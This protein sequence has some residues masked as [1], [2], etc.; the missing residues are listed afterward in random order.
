MWHSVE[1]RTPFS[2]DI[3]LMQ[4]AF[5]FNGNRKIKN[6]VSKYFLRKAVKDVL[7]DQIYNRYD[8]VGFE[9]P[10][11]SWV[12]QLKPKIIE[13]ITEAKFE[14]VDTSLLKKYLNSNDPAHLKMAFKLYVLATW[15]SVFQSI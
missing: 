2:D 13:A 11:F 14:F 5:S 7:P 6:G 3:D 4:L 8:K 12:E 9:T 10:M 15:K 1:S